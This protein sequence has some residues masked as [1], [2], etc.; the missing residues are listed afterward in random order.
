MTK[1]KLQMTIP[2][3]AL[4]VIAAAAILY[5]QLVISNPKSQE[6]HIHTNFAVYLNGVQYNFNQTKYM[7]DESNPLS[8]L[9]HIHDMN[10]GVVHIHQDGFTLGTFFQSIGIKLNSTCFTLDIGAAYCNSGS[11]TLKFYVNG[12]QSSLYD[13][14]RFSDLDKIL[15]TFGNDSQQTIQQQMS[16]IPSDACIYSEKCQAPPGFVNTEEI[17]C[18]TG[19]VSACTAPS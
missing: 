9:I 19:E 16:S 11:S 2:L 10:G 5:Y 8:A 7:E 14:Y 17:S 15:I 18:K 13:N 1:K 4:L 6:F 12:Q 3:V